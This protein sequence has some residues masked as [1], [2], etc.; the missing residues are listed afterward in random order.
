MRNKPH[1]LT[2]RRRSAFVSPRRGQSDTA[3]GFFRR[4]DSWPV[5]PAMQH[6]VA[7][8]RGAGG[9]CLEPRTFA[10]RMGLCVR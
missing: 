5:Y 2:A 7:V 6:P 9:R 4:G 1:P 8:A 3:R 10:V